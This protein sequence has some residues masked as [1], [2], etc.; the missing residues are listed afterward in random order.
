MPQI[1]SEVAKLVDKISHTIATDKII[2]F[3]SYAYGNPNEHSDIDL[4]V[5]T[6]DNIT[7]KRS[8]LKAIRKGIAPIASIPTDILIYDK[9]EF[10]QRAKLATTLEHEIESQGVSVYEK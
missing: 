3:G 8:L 2:L 4:C 9:E 5:I 10:K 1:S 6:R 7:R